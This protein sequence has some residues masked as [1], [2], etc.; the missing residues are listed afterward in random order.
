[1]NNFA[2]VLTVEKLAGVTPPPRA[3]VIRIM[4]AELFRLAS[5]LVWL[6][7][8]AS[9]IGA[10]SPVLFTF[11]DRERIFDIVEAITGGRMH[12]SFF[13]IGGVGPGSAEGWGRPGARIPGLSA[14]TAQGI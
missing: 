11:N 9:D 6:G 8:F 7:T 14:Q 12:P 5:H 10:M 3:Q 2:Y 1:M 4:L 13:R